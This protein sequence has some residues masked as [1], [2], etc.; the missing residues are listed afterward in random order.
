LVEDPDN[1]FPDDFS[2][3][4]FDGENYSVT[5]N[6]ITPNTGFIGILN[7]PVSVNDGTDNSVQFTVKVQVTKPLGIDD[8]FLKTNFSIYPNPFSN[9]LNINPKDFSEPYQI[10]IYTMNGVLIFSTFEDKRIGNSSIDLSSLI[11]GQYIL[12]VV[13]KNEEGITR[14]IKQE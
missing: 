12:K 7:V 5:N 14:I 4:V 3:T 11:K 9:H 1:S 6:E 13:T 10:K 8:H 2:L